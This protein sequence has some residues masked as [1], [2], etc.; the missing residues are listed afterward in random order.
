MHNTEVKK[1]AHD[2]IK[3]NPVAAIVGFI[4]GLVYR[5]DLGPLFFI[6][7]LSYG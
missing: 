1:T 6:K 4:L 5:G 7:L 2:L 3:G